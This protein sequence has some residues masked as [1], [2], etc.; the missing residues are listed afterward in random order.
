[1]RLQRR[2]DGHVATYAVAAQGIPALLVGADQAEGGV[3]PLGDLPTGTGEHGPRRVVSNRRSGDIDDERTGFIQGG[4]DDGVAQR[5]V[6][7]VV[8]HAADAEQACIR[9]PRQA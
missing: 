3:R 2:V 8:E 7:L 1:M 6:C 4:F 9:Y 5:N